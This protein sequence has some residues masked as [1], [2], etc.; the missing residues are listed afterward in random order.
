MNRVAVYGT[1]REGCSNRGLL[2]PYKFRSLGTHAL[3]G[4]K[5]FGGEFFPVAV[6]GNSFKDSMKVELIEVDDEALAAMDILEGIDFGLY[7]REK[8]KDPH[9]GEFYIYIWGS[10]TIDLPRIIDWRKHKHPEHFA[11]EA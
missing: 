7:T 3:D 9:L 8:V 6:I 10:D 11:V 4:F 1:L 5:L 2:A